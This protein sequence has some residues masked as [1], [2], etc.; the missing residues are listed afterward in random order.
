MATCQR[1]R[2]RTRVVIAL[3]RGPVRR[4]GAS[5]THLSADWNGD[6]KFVVKR[7]R[8]PL[9]WRE[10]EEGPRSKGTYA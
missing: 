6:G 2:R 9:R 10:A 8:G 4:D 5:D 7:C 1:M 3:R